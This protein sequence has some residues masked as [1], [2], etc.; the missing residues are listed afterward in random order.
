MWDV[1]FIT[2]MRGMMDVMLV[3]VMLLFFFFMLKIFFSLDDLLVSKIKEWDLINLILLFESIWSFICFIFWEE[4]LLRWL[5]C[6]DFHWVL[7]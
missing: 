3:S 4:V 1:H 7:V 6:C 5:N 2:F